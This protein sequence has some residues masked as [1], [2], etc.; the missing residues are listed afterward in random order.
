MDAK[1]KEIFD[2]IRDNILRLRK[3][4]DMSVRK[5]ADLADIDAGSLNEFELGKKL[6]NRHYFT[7]CVKI[8]I[9]VFRPRF[10]NF[11]TYTAK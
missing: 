3:E 4:H 1:E 7:N 8:K 10:F 6:I 5:L 11:K 2:N 9:E